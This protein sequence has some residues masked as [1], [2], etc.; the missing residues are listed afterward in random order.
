MSYIAAKCWDKQSKYCAFQ[1]GAGQG[2][3]FVAIL[4][5]ERHVREQKSVT[6]VVPDTIS[7]G[8]Y[9]NYVDQYCKN[10]VIVMQA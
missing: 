8:Q 9:E 6:I 3:T 2:K 7:V 1:L 5:A 10:N 4:L